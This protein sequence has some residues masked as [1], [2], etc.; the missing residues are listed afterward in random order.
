MY[1]VLQPS[2]DVKS[3]QVEEKKRG[4]YR[5]KKGG[6]TRKWRNPAGDIESQT[7]MSPEEYNKIYLFTKGNKNYVTFCGITFSL[8]QY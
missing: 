3:G 5:L 8:K 6:A 7:K 4:D 1:G 2:I